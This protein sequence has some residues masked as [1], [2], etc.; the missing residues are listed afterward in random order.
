MFS[1]G[2][3]S[4][5]V[6]ETRK[7]QTDRRQTPVFA[8]FIIPIRLETLKKHSNAIFSEILEHYVIIDNWT[9]NERARRN[10]ALAVVTIK[11]IFPSGVGCRTCPVIRQ[12]I[13]VGQEVFECD[14]PQNREFG[15]FSIRR[16]NGLF[17]QSMTTN[18]GAAETP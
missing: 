3:F 17:G 16:D 15:L 13:A 4:R 7:W 10:E 11:A 18:T 2:R 9:G 1:I 6:S 14:S 12:A 5:T 8:W